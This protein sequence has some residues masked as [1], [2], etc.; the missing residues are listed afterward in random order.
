MG[1]VLGD[2]VEPGG[3]PAVT[4]T[5]MT[6][7]K[8]GETPVAGNRQPK[9]GMLLTDRF[10][11]SREFCSHKIQ[12]H[13]NGQNDFGNRYNQRLMSWSYTTCDS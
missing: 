1:I 6:Y 4:S 13:W 11:S 10:F 12:Y 7:G 2:V 9:R 5:V 3:P 8:V